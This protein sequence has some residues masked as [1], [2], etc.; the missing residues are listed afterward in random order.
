MRDNILYP[1]LLAELARNG[2]SVRDLA[3]A[4]GMTNQN[5]Y[6]KLRGNTSVNE[7]DMREIQKYFKDINGGYFSIDYLFSNEPIINERN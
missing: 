6:S 2:A 5:L 3:E 4:I 1:N 7:K